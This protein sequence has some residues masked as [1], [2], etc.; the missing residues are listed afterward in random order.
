MSSTPNSSCNV[1]ETPSSPWIHNDPPALVYPSEY[2]SRVPSPDDPIYVNSRT[3]SPRTLTPEEIEE[4]LVSL[5]TQLGIRGRRRT[6]AIAIQAARVGI[7]R[8]LYD[9][10][11]DVAIESLRGDN[12]PHDHPNQDLIPNRPPQEV[13]GEILV[14]SPEPLPVRPRLS[15]V[16]EEQPYLCPTLS[17]PLHKFLRCCL[18]PNTPTPHPSN[19]TR[20]TNAIT[21]PTSPL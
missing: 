3:P 20:S 10:P 21:R 17:N 7:A 12:G 2:P 15:P 9:A 11:V 18:G 16:D 8:I 13:V 6:E 4:V 19:T 1:S 14:E 5:S